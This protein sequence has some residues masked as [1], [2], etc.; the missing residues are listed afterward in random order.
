VGTAHRNRNARKNAMTQKTIFIVDD[1]AEFRQS[2][3]WW[4]QGA[5]YQ[6]ESFESPS[7]ALDQLVGRDAPEQVCV[8]L[9]VRMPEMSGLDL[10]DALQA[11]GIHSP[12]IYMT[13]HGAVPLA[14][15][16]MKKGAV[17]FLEKPLDDVALESA[18]QAA[19]SRRTAA[20]FRLERESDEPDPAQIA[21]QARYAK[22]TPR[23][24]EVLQGVVD[25]KL[26][27]TSA[28]HLDI[29]VKTVEVHRAR[30]IAKL[31]AKSL[32]HL[33]RM[34]VTGRVPELCDDD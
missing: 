30:A 7:R 1:N 25:G 21:Y 18:L 6:V 14:V 17:T 31:E 19:F 5:G 3:E 33:T 20:S 15:D 12:V 11:K 23:E 27:K 32:A 8:L 13:G 4:L 10:H 22:L 29:S 26:N 24:R 2:A 16:A 9:D 28:D 34:V